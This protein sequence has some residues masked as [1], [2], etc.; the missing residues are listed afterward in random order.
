MSVS[1]TDAN[2][3][4]PTFDDVSTTQADLQAAADYAEKAFKGESVAAAANLPATGNWLGRLIFATAE[5]AIYVCTAL[6]N[7]WAQVADGQIVPITSVSTGFAA[8]A[9]PNAPRILRQGNR[10]IMFGEVA[11]TS[12][13]TFANV[14]TVPTA[15]QPPT[16]SSRTI[17]IGGVST[18]TAGSLVLVR[19]TLAA[20]VLGAAVGSGSIPAGTVYLSGLTWLMD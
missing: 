1:S 9:A 17:G 10:R 7:T 16:A 19:A 14:L 8:N 3:Q 18:G 5:A 4:K 12:G 6:P 15:D 20:G 11:F 13:G 2:T